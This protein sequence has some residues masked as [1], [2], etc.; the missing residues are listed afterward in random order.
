MDNIKSTK[1]KN[2]FKWIGL[3]GI[4]CIVISKAG[5]IVINQLDGTKTIDMNKLL[6][7]VLKVSVEEEPKN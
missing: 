4:G 6:E 1:Y 3:I 5:I 7:L 2:T